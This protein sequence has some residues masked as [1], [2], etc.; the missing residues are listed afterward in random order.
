MNSAYWIAKRLYF[1]QQA[2]GTR[3]SR[4]AV[5]VALAGIIIGVMVMVLTVC[6]VVGFKQTIT[7]K[8][9]GFGA[10]IQV[11]NFDNN[12][13]YEMQPIEV[14][15]SLMQVLGCFP[16]VASAHTFLTK[17]GIMKTDDAFQGIVF[18]GTDYWDYFANNLQ[19][20]SLPQKPDE[21]LISRKQANALALTLSDHILSYFVD[22]QV[23]ARKFTITGIYETGFSDFDNL[24]VVGLPEVVRRLNAW[25]STQV[26]GIEILLDDIRYLDQ[27]AEEI[28]FATLHLLDEHG[29]HIYYVQ[30]LHQ[31]NPQVFAWL[32]LLDMNVVVIILLMLAVSAF[33]II[34]GLIIL[35]LDS[36]QLIGVLKAL[37]AD[38]T[39][40]RRIFI[41]QAA[42]L[43]GKGML[44][45]NI[46]ALMLA[47]AQCFTHAIPLDPATYYV[48]FVPVAFPCE[49]LLTLNAGILLVSLIV[50]LAPS[51]IITRISPAKV[52]HFD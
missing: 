43:I 45:G 14:S 36:V 51:A 25:D 3:R 41:A 1:T 7:D 49:W 17:P 9:A 10:H 12:N 24:F 4:P 33:T 31:L 18:K 37:G 26:S 38:N 16:H 8:V 11:V 35:I 32:D 50:L 34:S 23:R 42:M 20:G 27:T 39:Y 15:D 6:V 48:N 47:L 46:L 21:V 2:D 40:V 22:E 28:Y 30:T 13:T 5:R 52:M 19:E 44:W 29:Y